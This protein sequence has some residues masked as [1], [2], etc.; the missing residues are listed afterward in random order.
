MHASLALGT[1]LLAALAGCAVG[2]DFVRPSA[3]TT[4]RY[5][6]VALPGEVITGDG[7]AQRFTNGAA[8]PKQWWREFG[9][10]GLN[11]SVSEALAHSPSLAAAAA[12]LRETEDTRRAGY[13]VFMPQINASL[14]ASRERLSPLQ[15]G[16][17]GP[18]S[19]FNLFTLSGSVG[20]VI[21][22]FGG[23]RRKVEVLG[24]QVDVARA[25]ANAAYLALTANVANTTITR[26]AYLAEADATRELIRSAA[27]QLRLTQVQADAGTGAYSDVLDA[28]AQL[29]GLQ[30]SLPELQQHADQAAHLLSVLVGHLPAEWTPPDVSFDTLTLPQDIPLSLPSALVQQRPD[31]LLAEGELHAA[32]AS[33]GVATSNLLPTLTLSGSAGSVANQMSTLGKAPGNIWSVGGGLSVPV[34]QGGTAWYTRKAT[35]EAYQAS[36]ANY[37]QTVLAAFEQVADTL[38]AL[39]HDGEAVRAA[40]DAVKATQTALSLTQSNYESGVTGFL[41]VL[42]A[43]R[44]YQTA[45]LAQMQ[46][47]GQRLQ[48]TVALFI[49]LG[50]DWRSAPEE[51]FKAK[52]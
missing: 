50:G 22:L 19:V 40:A 30:A 48:D 11:Q 23:E 21:D 6:A 24:A 15:L 13:G 25:Q 46:A 16:N 18:G 44:Q 38:R 35:L 52:P 29:A 9:A 39:E 28:Q 49:A 8:V 5:T 4:D 45:R 17:S 7:N 37:R 26:A 1:A 32:S 33:I 42:A 31:V 3:P 51:Q 34:F 14:G 12:T 27:E 20:Y 36:V 47:V 10:D 41:S 43:D 2:P